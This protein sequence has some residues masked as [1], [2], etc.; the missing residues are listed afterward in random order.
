MGMTQKKIFFRNGRLKKTEF[1][2]TD[3]SQYYIFHQNCINETV[4]LI[5]A[6]FPKNVREGRN[7]PIKILQFSDEKA[8]RYQI[9]TILT[10]V[11]I[12]LRYEFKLLL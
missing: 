6:Y 3:N 7:F 12:D 8:K 9:F 1:L 5:K 2:K 11:L 10:F 4:D